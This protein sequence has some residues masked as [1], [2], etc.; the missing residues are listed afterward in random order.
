MKKLSFVFII[1]M[2][3]FIITGCESK[4]EVDVSNMTHQLCE[5]AGS[6]DNG[7]VELKYD[8]YFTGD[9]LNMIKS[10]EKVISDDS[11]ILD[12]YEE[13]YK[14]IHSAYVGL[15]YYDTDVVRDDNSVTSTMNINYDKVDI[16]KLIEIEGEEDNI[17]EDGEAK[18]K[19]WK[20]LAKKFGTKCTDVTEES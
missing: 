3:L 6:I 16:D 1:I 5:R 19:K 14:K 12:T 17:F 2:S 13:S 20:A 11:S 18:V 7:E 15:S 10:F 8:I 4:E 9:K